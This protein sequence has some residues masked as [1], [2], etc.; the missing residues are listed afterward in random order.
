MTT[1]TSSV[2]VIACNYAEAT[3][4]AKRGAKAFLIEPYDGERVE[5]Y[6]R[7]RGGRW[8]RKWEQHKRTCNWRVV[9]VVEAGLPKKVFEAI[10]RWR[11]SIDLER[12]ATAMNE[13]KP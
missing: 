3:K 1:T 4:I 6:V 9:S 7:S 2:R 12:L 11:D 5:L 8:V 10:T 13:R